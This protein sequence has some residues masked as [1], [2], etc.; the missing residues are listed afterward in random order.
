[1]EP[2]SEPEIEM[3]E[4]DLSM[5]EPEIE[6]CEKIE[7][8]WDP[9][10]GSKRKGCANPDRS[11]KIV[12]RK[13]Y[14]TK[15]IQSNV[16]GKRA[17]YKVFDHETFEKL[18]HMMAT[19]EEICNFLDMSRLKLM[20]KVKEHYKAAKYDD[21]YKKLCTGGIISLRR[22]QFN[23]SRTNTAMAI[24]LGKQYLNQSEYK[25]NDKTP[26]VIEQV[27]YGKARKKT[28]DT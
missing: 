21:V 10:T 2:E 25:G 17:D 15:L 7:G 13:K 16:L 28:E 26:L 18:C 19:T 20:E 22:S 14:P 6:E 9:L 3:P 1:M 8:D 24:W 23:L 11:R 12:V 5:E 4:L 27:V